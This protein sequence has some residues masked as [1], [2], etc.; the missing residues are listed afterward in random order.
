MNKVVV[1]GQ[2]AVLVSKDFGA[3]WSTWNNQYPEIVFD[4]FIVN[5]LL[6]DPKDLEKIQAY[7]SI[8]YP[9]AY[10]GGIDTVD[11]EW[12]PEGELFRVEEYDGRERVITMQTRGW[13]K[14]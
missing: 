6:K 4:P 14:A 10:T 11:I 1:N 3:G 2:V 7:V 5:Q 8:K 13:I 9:D 12:V